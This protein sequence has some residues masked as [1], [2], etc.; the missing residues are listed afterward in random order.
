MLSGPATW[1]EV[2]GRL[3]FLATDGIDAPELWATSGTPQS[4]VALTDAGPCPNC[5]NIDPGDFQPVANGHRVIFIAAT[6]AHG[7]ELWATDGT[8]AGTREL[9]DLCTGSCSTFP[10]FEAELL[11]WPGGAIFRAARPDFGPEIWFSDGS[12]PGT[13]R[14]TTVPG[15]PQTPLAAG[16][17]GGSVFFGATDDQ[18]G[19]LWVSQGAAKT[20][21][22]TVLGRTER[23]A[24]PRELTAVGDRLFFSACT[25]ATRE[26]WTTRGTPESTAATGNPA[27]AQPC[28]HLSENLFL[29]AGNRVF[30]WSLVDRNGLWVS[31]GTAA[32]TV[33]LLSTLDSLASPSL[34]FFQGK[35]YFAQYSEF[36]YGQVL[37]RTDGTPAGTQPFF[38]LPGDQRDIANLTVIGGALYFTAEDWETRQTVLWV[39][40]G[41]A[42]GTRELARMQGVYRDLGNDDPGADFTV[43]GSTIFLRGGDGRLWKTDGTPG[44]TV[45]VAPDAEDFFPS[46]LTALDGVLYALSR[47]SLWRSN[48]T[49]AGT[50][51]VRDLPVEDTHFWSVSGLTAFDGRLYFAASDDSDGGHGIELWT[52]DGTGAGTRMLADLYPGA[53][54]SRP[55]GF[56]E[57]GGRLYFTATD[58]DHGRELW[59]TDGTAEGTRLVEDL[60]PQALSS[61]PAELT[62]VG[63]RLY[64]VADDGLTGRELWALPLDQATGCQPSGQRLCLGNGRFAVR[65]DWRDFQ[66]GTGTGQAVALSAD[67]GYFWFFNPA[68]V[69]TVIK[70]LD[71]RGVN[72]HHWVFYGAL[73]NVQYSLT[74]TD[75]ATGAVRRYFN[76]SSQ[77]ASV[78]DTRGFGRLGAASS[79]TVVAPPSPA[80][81]VRKTTAAAAIC[82]P[83]ATRL[84]LNNGRFAV[85]VAWK[86]F[87]GN[88]GTGKAVTLTADTG[89]FWFF[90]AANVEVVLKV[91]DGRELND[92]F[93]V[94]YGAL[95]NVEYTITVTDTQT[96]AVRTYVNPAGQFA[97][98]GDTAAF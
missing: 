60:N 4:T 48:G 61:D 93:W 7:R 95:S 64:F 33:Q 79:E 34:A 73:S 5:P 47:N 12:A 59:R 50:F 22:L 74:V 96:G 39:T 20:R 66:G 41:T 21:L 63:N 15:E 2:N 14:L 57:A 90:D 86:D 25:G 40:D 92:R 27:A 13:F 62:V 53:G 38:D 28:A 91:L 69:E 49:D 67:T 29:A 37:W 42:A 94:F 97:S 26:V 36:G 87:Q 84:C 83:S 16:R 54:S 55:A 43:I 71:G 68:N 19:A 81:R 65:A 11:P 98:V 10:S 70:V 32:G 24:A 23:A 82:E 80:A 45:R 1:K 85:Q 35:V 89:Y 44:G 51:L 17:L 72:E 75:T 8:P 52:S 46:E 88:T 30:Y 58:P 31:D 9:H 76:P 56:T 18:G 77:F 3:V 78:G 6:Q